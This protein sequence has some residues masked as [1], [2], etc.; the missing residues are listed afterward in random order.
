MSEHYDIILIGTG[1]GGG[2]IAHR[3]ASRS[4]KK[5]LILERGDFLRREKE[6]WDPTAVFVDNRYKAHET[7][8]DKN[9]SPFHPGIQYYVGGNTKVYGA[10]LFRL[11]ERDFGEIHHKGGI[12]PAWPIRY[13]DLSSHYDEAEEMYQVHGEHGVDPTDP[14]ARKPYPF[15]P[16]SNEPRIQ[17][18][19]DD[20]KKL[21]LHPFPLP[22]GVMLKENN[23]SESRCIRCDTCDGF[24]CLVDAKSDAQVLGI[25]P[26]RHLPHVTLLTNAK[27]EKLLTDSSGKRVTGVEVSR[28][29]NR[30]TFSGDLV[31]VSCGAVNSAVLLLQSANDKHPNGLANGS[32][33]VGR[34][35]MCHNN[36]AFVAI[37]TRPN[38]TKFQ[39]TLGINDYY[40]ESKEYN[41]PLGHIQMLG[42]SHAAMFEA[43]APRFTPGIALKEM[44]KH[45]MDFWLTSEDLPDPNN[46]VK[47]GKDGSIHLHY[48]DNNLEPHLLLQEK[49]KSILKEIGCETHL[50]PKTIY[51]GKKI[52]IAG[53][54]HQCGTVRFGK[55]PQSSALDPF[56]KAHELDNLYVVDGSFF[57]SSG[58]VNPGLTIIAN[59]LRI[60]DHILERIG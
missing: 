1:A 12:S 29:G 26:I 44:A 47:L 42:K 60:G 25:D 8:Y 2:T 58:A 4:S 50:I 13:E 51:L 6:N 3:L 18:L 59:A 48:T 39:K 52:P 22:M 33:V 11:R 32:G 9:E 30:E 17:E 15:P 55:D 24:P 57:C 19:W 43:D 10:A 53:T 41:F 20:L 56:C 5:I 35:Y 21:G 28:E 7:W 14:K 37:S 31:I 16:V 27:A 45:A 23:Y 49:L 38:P 54:A 40:Y 46:R 34:H 36:S